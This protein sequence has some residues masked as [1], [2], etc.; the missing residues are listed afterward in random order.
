MCLCVCTFR[1]TKIPEKQ[2]TNEKKKRK[3]KKGPKFRIPRPAGEI[4]RADTARATRIS[5]Q[6]QQQQQHGARRAASTT[7]GRDKLV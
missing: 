5:H 6:Q 3:E 2:E 7:G 4:E 1:K